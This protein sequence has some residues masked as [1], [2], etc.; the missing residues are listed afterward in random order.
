M[1]RIPERVLA[2]LATGLSL[3]GLLTVSAA[4]GP[5]KSPCGKCPAC[6]CES[7]HESGTP[8]NGRA[9]L[10]DLQKRQVHHAGKIP[11]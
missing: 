10:T 9:S 1:I 3:A 5:S 2:V 11:A 7:F 6:P 4:R 8:S